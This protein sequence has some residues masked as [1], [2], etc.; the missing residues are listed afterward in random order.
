[1]LDAGAFL[2]ALEY[3]GDCT[4]LVMGKPS[5]AFFTEV[6]RS[7]GLPA[8]AF[9]MVVDDVEADVCGA[10]AAGIAAVLV[11]IGKYRPG[12]E[13]LLPEGCAVISG[14]RDLPER[15]GW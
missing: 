9:L 4:A 11:Q 13:D 10:A 14:I 15:L 3:G 12:D 1:M 5:A 7:L 2:Q 8:E 6:V